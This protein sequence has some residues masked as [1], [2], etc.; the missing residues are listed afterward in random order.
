MNLVLFV[1]NSISIA[2]FHQHL[3]NVSNKYLV[4]NNS[5]H[6]KKQI[7]G[8]CVASVPFSGHRQI[9]RCSAVAALVFFD[10][11]RMKRQ[12]DNKTNGHKF[13]KGASSTSH[14]RH[15]LVGSD[16][17]K[18]SHVIANTDTRRLEE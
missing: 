16:D 14:T 12:S 11:V 15:V 8:G 3:K 9:D 1:A 18:T 5:K 7:K 17:D 10:S 6:K 2:L 13:E 4:M